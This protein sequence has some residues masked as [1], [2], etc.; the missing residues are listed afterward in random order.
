M[1]SASIILVA[2]LIAAPLHAQEEPEEKGF[3][4]KTVDWVAETT[5]TKE[6][7]EQLRKVAQ[8][9]ADPSKCASS[10]LDKA[11]D[12][13]L[14]IMPSNLGG[15]I[16]WLATFYLLSL[17]LQ[18]RWPNSLANATLGILFVVSWGFV[19][20]L[21]G[22]DIEWLGYAF[23]IT[24]LLVQP[25]WLVHLDLIKPP[26]R[27]W[28]R[29]AAKTIDEVVSDGTRKPDSPENTCPTPGCGGYVNDWFCEGGCGYSRPIEGQKEAES[30][31]QP[32]AQLPQPLPQP[33]PKD[34][35][36]VLHHP[37]NL[38]EVVRLLK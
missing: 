18:T 31:T 19:I 2:A 6:E 4:G 15:L 23:V 33:A 25:E 17:L 21:K 13:C 20:V 9:K 8:C 27:L 37:Q 24:P 28:P 5:G 34:S 1:K 3:A 7:L 29:P 26:I 12:K 16:A 38:A 22:L 30:E 10:L 14:V 35:K 11:W 32:Q 36:I